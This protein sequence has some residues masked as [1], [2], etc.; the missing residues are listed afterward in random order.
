M[1]AYSHADLPFERLVEVINPARSLSRHPLFQVMLAYQSEAGCGR[2]PEFA[3]L[4]AERCGGG[5]G[6]RE[7]RPVGERVGASRR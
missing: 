1:A 2:L 4:S 7:V 3:G 6:E 5:D